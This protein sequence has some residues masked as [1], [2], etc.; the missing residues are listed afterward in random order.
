[1]YHREDTVFVLYVYTQEQPAT[2]TD[3]MY[4]Q[5]PFR[6]SLGTGHYKVPSLK[7][8]VCFE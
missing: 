7:G 4:V 2:L 5:V 6:Y 8:L 1:M 3:L